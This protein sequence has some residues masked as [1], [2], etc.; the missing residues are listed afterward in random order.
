MQAYKSHQTHLTGAEEEAAEQEDIKRLGKVVDGAFESVGK[1]TNLSVHEVLHI[2]EEVNVAQLKKAVQEAIKK[3]ADSTDLDGVQ[4]IAIFMAN[5]G[6]SID[7]I[8]NRLHQQ[9]K[10]NRHRL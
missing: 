7:D 9:S 1:L 6:A 10:E 2:I 5:R 4:I 8:V 3:I